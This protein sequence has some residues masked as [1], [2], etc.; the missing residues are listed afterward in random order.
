MKKKYTLAIP[1]LFTALGLSDQA[2]ADE[3]AT[4]NDSSNDLTTAV[5]STV[6]EQGKLEEGAVATSTY[7]APSISPKVAEPRVP[8]ISS[9]SK[10]DNE[11]STQSATSPAAK[12]ETE[13]VAV[14]SDN[15]VTNSSISKE[16]QIPE[17]KISK[18][19]YFRNTTSPTYNTHTSLTDATSDKTSVKVTFDQANSSS[20]DRFKVG[21]YTK[22]DKSDIIWKEGNKVVNG[23]A[24]F[25]MRANELQGVTAKY[26]FDPIIRYKNGSQKQGATLSHDLVNPDLPKV[27]LQNVSSD[28]RNLQVVFDKASSEKVSL[29]KVGIYTKA[30]K[31]DIQWKEGNIV[32]GQKAW[33]TI[34][35][36]DF[37]KNVDKVFFDTSV[38]LKDGKT[39]SLGTLNH[40]IKQSVV[41]T[42]T[43]KPQPTTQPVQTPTISLKNLS[44]DKTS[45]QVVFN[46]TNPSQLTELKVGVYT[47]K[48]KSDLIWKI[49]HN[50]TSGQSHFTIA[51]DELQKVSGT[52]YFDSVSV[53]K[54]G[55]TINHPTISQ[56]LIY[57]NSDT[58]KPLP[59]ESKAGFVDLSSH[60]GELSEA[61]FRELARQGIRGAVVKLTEHTTY[62]NPFA[63]SHIKNAKAAGLQVSAYAYSH[64]QSAEDARK[65]A[66]F[67]VQRA[68]E[69]GLPSNTVMVNDIEENYMRTNI[70]ANTQ[71]WADEMRRQGF[72]NLI[73][74]ASASWLDQNN[75]GIR[76][77]I[78]TSQFGLQNF[79]VAQYPAKNM[80]FSQAR[81]MSYNSRTAAWQFGSDAELIKGKHVFDV[82]IDYTGRFTSNT[83][84]PTSQPSKPVTPTPQPKPTTN[85]SEFKVG[86]NVLF[87]GT[88]TISSLAYPNVVSKDLA[89]QTGRDG[90]FDPTPMVEVDGAGRATSDQIL[91]SGS[92]VRIPGT[93]KVLAVDASKSAVKV[94]IGSRESWVDSRKVTKTTTATTPNTNPVTSASQGNYNVLNRIIYLDAGHGGSDPGAVRGNVREAEL[95]LSVHNKLRRRLEQEGFKVISTR[96]DN[97]S[98][99]LTERSVNAN[100]SFSDLFVSLHFNASEKQVDSSKEGIETYWYQYFPEYYPSMNA[101]FHNNPQRLER[102]QYLATAIQNNL[103]GQTHAPNRGVKRQTFSVLRE[104]VAPAV[105]VELGFVSHANEAQKIVQSAYQDKLVAGV[106]NGIKEYYKH[107]G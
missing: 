97:S 13:S 5:S 70:N 56:N 12:T 43:P 28:K 90:V 68:K 93:Y 35:S 47:K 82:N 25:T 58:N 10:V 24:W 37:A 64:Y 61:D 45:V 26:Y 106:L 69:L 71:A 81:G 60:N 107:F 75:L 4:R 72:S 83:S 59:K 34:H 55:K 11:A 42:P 6:A 33:F 15:H 101:A 2:Q 41:P 84:A 103:I 20:I 52:Y 21:V 80:T 76:G 7:S 22:N 38:R 23:K 49:G 53:L 87:N 54:G 91:Y 19:T 3:L 79:W 96:T 62:K 50:I 74:Y 51:T 86:D 27:S 73:Y 98:H 67:F 66:R 29:F 85:T 65:E 46:N 9:S 44:A 30:N 104:T 14:T 99:D 77:P 18:G 57:K 95:A 105:L 1:L 31:S 48:D 102:S 78:S 88:Y 8:E 39:I 36:D 40:V 92:L 63:A 32:K 17:N 100:R 94:R 89:G 16:T